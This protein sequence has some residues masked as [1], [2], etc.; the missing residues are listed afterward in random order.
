MFA[1]GE[2]NLAS[3]W[4]GLGRFMQD[5]ELRGLIGMPEDYQIVAP[6]ILGHPR[7]IPGVPQM[8]DPPILMAVD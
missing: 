3:C 2:R 1:A 4:S 8:A 7:G 5:P 6:F